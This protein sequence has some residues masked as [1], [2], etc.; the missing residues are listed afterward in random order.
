MCPTS[1]SHKCSLLVLF[2]LLMTSA[3]M[4]GRF[5][6]VT[7]RLFRRAVPR[8]F[9]LEGNAIPVERDNSTLIETPAGT[10][11]LFALI[12]TAGFASQIQEKYSGMLI[13]EGRL[14]ICGKPAHI[15]SYGFGIRQPSVPSGHA[16][17][18]LYDQAGHHILGCRMGRNLVMRKPRPLQIAIESSRS[19]RLYL[20]CNWVELSP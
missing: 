20:G 11:A 12:V 15:G 4:P 2:A 6:I 18:V 17:F 9:Y 1:L 19:A 10:R 3:A 14:S 8:D 7:G 13:S 5:G 16:Q